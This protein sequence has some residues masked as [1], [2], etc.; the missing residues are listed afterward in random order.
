VDGHLFFPFFPCASVDTAA[1]LGAQVVGLQL[2]LLDD[3]GVEV[4]GQLI[5]NVATQQLEWAPDAPLRPLTRHTGYW[6]H[7]EGLLGLPLPLADGGLGLEVDGGLQRA[8]DVMFETLDATQ[9]VGEPV[10]PQVQSVV[11]TDHAIARETCCETLSYCECG[12]CEICRA[13]SWDYLPRL[14]VTWNPPTQARGVHGYVVSLYRLE[15]GGETLEASWHA[16]WSEET[17]AVQ[18]D[19]TKRASTYC[20]V[21]ETTRLVDG[22]KARSQPVCK[23]DADLVEGQRL[24]PEVTSCKGKLSWLRGGCSSA[25]E[26]SMALLACVVV[27]LANRR[28]RLRARVSRG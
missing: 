28:L 22:M 19:Y 17:V 27:G 6:T 20:A 8:V 9:H 21:L 18:L 24:E 13:M 25:D 1:V 12:Q 4:P 7:S 14:L 3:R 2:H 15:D 26:G 10:P 5:L 23:V 16:E 11:F